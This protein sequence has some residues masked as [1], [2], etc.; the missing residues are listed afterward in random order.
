MGYAVRHKMPEFKKLIAK[1]KSHY[2][3]PKL[4]PAKGPFELVLWENACYLLPDDRRAAVFEGL[5]KQVGPNAKAILK[6]DP[7]VLLT[8]ATM[9]GMRPKVRVFRWQ[10][11]ARITLSQFDGDLDHILTLPLCAGQ[12]GI[13]TIP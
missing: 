5:R 9:G 1:L 10:E 4:P 7:D 11:I 6:A 2:D 3:V 13:E 12:K 8:L